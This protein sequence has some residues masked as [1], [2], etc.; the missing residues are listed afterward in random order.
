MKCLLR[1]SCTCKG[2]EPTLRMF[3][4][5]VRVEEQPL[6]L[7]QIVMFNAL[8]ESTRQPVIMKLRTFFS[9]Q[10]LDYFREQVTRGK[11]PGSDL[12]RFHFSEAMQIRNAIRAVAPDT[13]VPSGNW[14][15]YY[16]GAMVAAVQPDKVTA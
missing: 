6:D 3:C 13:M 14:D 7:A 1:E 12:P 16:I 8:P 11:S 9:P 2:K 10:W 5:H 4:G 15:D